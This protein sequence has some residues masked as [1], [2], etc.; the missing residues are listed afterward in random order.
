M[1][2]WD[3]MR[4]WMIWASSYEFWAIDAS[5]YQRN[6][7]KKNTITSLV[8]TDQQKKMQTQRYL[9]TRKIKAS[10]SKLSTHNT[11]QSSRV[12]SKPL[13]TT[14]VGCAAYPRNWPKSCGLSCRH[15]L[16]IT[17]SA[18]KGRP[19]D[20]L[21]QSQASQRCQR[22]SRL[23]QMVAYLWGSMCPRYGVLA[24]GQ[25]DEKKGRVRIV[26]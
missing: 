4:D 14:F 19:K 23:L 18:T 21:G 6:Y 24:I 5:W 25:G 9:A 22:S 12:P 10:S 13:N 2:V 20:W 8:K 1:F 11:S 17:A 26:L 16:N 3:C 15:Q 7:G